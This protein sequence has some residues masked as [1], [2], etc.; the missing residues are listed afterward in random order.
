MQ[1]EFG[2]FCLDLAEQR[3]FRDGRP[4]PLT[5]KIFA[6]LTVLV[7]H[8]G[9]LVEKERLLKEV[10][11]DTFV[12]E[13]NL[14]RGVSVLRKA[15]GEGTAGEKYIETVPK[16][17]YRFIAPVR[18]RPDAG[19]TDRQ[20][21]DVS[22]ASVAEAAAL[23]PSSPLPPRSAVRTLAIAAGL[24]LAIA[25]ILYAMFGR[26]ALDRSVV[27]TKAP[28]HRQLTFGGKEVTP[29]LSPDGR[30][31]AYVSTESPHR[32]VISQD[33]AGGEP[34]VVFS[35][36]EAGALRWSPD[37][38]EL[39]FWARGGGTDGL[40]IAPASGT[41]ARKIRRGLFVS[42]WSP[43][44]ST[45][46]LAL[47][48]AKKILFL[49]RLGEVQRTIALQGTREWIWDLDWSPVHDRLLLVV[50][51]DQNRPAVWTIRPDGSEQTK[52]F[53][54]DTEIPAARWAPTGD[55]IYYF[56]RVNQTVTLYKF[57][58]RPDDRTKE[59]VAVPLI[60][61]L[62]TDGSL[63][64][65]ADGSRL[66][67]ARARYSS[68]LWLVD[69]TRSAHGQE[70]R[71]T[72]LTHGT[73][74]VERPRVSPDGQSILFN[75]GY[76][77]RANLYTMP[78]T[79]GT[80][81]QLTFLNAFSVGGVWSADGRKVA[82][83][84]TEGGKARVWV[85]NADG[86]S[87]HPVSTGEMSDVFSVAWSPG[88]RLL[89]QQ[90]GNQNFYTVDLQTRQETLLIKDSSVGWASFAEYSPD[91][92][93]IAVSWNRRPNRGVWVIDSETLRESLI[94]ETP[95]PSES[96]PVPIGWSPDGTSIYAYDGIRAANRGLS[97]SYGE[98]ITNA[99]ILRV[100]LD[101]GPPTRIADLPFEEVGG[102]AL[103]PDGRQLVCAVYS[104]QSDVWV[105][106]DFDVSTESRVAR[107]S[108]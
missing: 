55:A 2:A 9:H 17:G 8:A 33:L 51:D 49:N 45:I 75:M 7:Q 36:P 98:T 42:C 43:D 107:R 82:F 25:A 104:A 83:A 24:V 71:K 60:S 108:K 102:I 18:V 58:L 99:R 101:G 73:S 35:A 46:A 41:G 54:A 15:L 40:Y 92:K 106:E 31:I 30:R 70:L 88:S 78:A 23:S 59:R 27:A 80:P 21:R 52:L 61:G 4:V 6:L 86:S 95:N 67:Y 20:G 87:L 13:A 32:K 105:V 72:Q 79:G 26:S 63:G 44:G 100:P 28:R 1:Y 3:L 62:E 85:V 81:R 53:T 50:N 34:E 96:N 76:E 14:N 37:G 11:P 93:K 22:Q 94:H 90:T 16:R 89:Y 48:V 38:S 56:N 5:P 39:M 84:S 69:V 29:T 74:V 103:F 97:V 12:E 10:W 19:D 91:G 68:N 64:L 57:V 65:S 77:S 66:V 47:F